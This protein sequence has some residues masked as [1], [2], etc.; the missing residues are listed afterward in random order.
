MK[1]E[2]WENKK[3]GT[4]VARHDDDSELPEYLVPINLFKERGDRLLVARK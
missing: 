4:H 3:P 1:E 2:R